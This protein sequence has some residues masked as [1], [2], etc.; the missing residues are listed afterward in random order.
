[1]TISMA[2]SAVSADDSISAGVSPI[3]S[4]SISIMLRVFFISPPFPVQSL[5][6]TDTYIIPNWLL[7]LNYYIIKLFFIIADTK[8]VITLIKNR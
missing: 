7:T 8:N 3:N 4:R 6:Q 2:S 5:A 1:M